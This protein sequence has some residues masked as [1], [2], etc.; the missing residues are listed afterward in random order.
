MPIMRSG[1]LMALPTLLCLT[2][3]VVSPHGGPAFIWTKQGGGS[4]VAE[5]SG[6]NGTSYKRAVVISNSAKPSFTAGIE[7]TWLQE[8][9][10]RLQEG[11]SLQRVS[12]RINDRTY[13]VVTITTETGEIK[14]FYFDVTRSNYQR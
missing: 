8:H 2:G 9:K 11:S 4:P 10:M 1:L 14:V 7:E 6:G 3:C 5:V 13:D 12:E